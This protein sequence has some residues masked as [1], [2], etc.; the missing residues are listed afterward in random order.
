MIVKF[1]QILHLHYKHMSRLFS[2]SNYII[3][4]ICTAPITVPSALHITS[5]YA[6]DINSTYSVV[7]LVV[8]GLVVVWP[9]TLTTVFASY[10]DYQLKINRQQKNVSNHNRDKS[11]LAKEGNDV[12]SEKV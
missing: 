6:D 11:T 9:L 5:T 12:L 1:L 10:V 4:M 8:P 2:R 7:F 3:G